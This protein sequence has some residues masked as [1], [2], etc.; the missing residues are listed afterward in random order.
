MSLRL[1]RVDVWFSASLIFCR[2]SRVGWSGVCW[3][4]GGWTRSDLSILSA[5]PLFLNHIW[6]QPADSCRLL[7]AN[8]PTLRVPPW[9]AGNQT[10]RPQLWKLCFHLTAQ[11]YFNSYLSTFIFW[12]SKW[13]CKSLF[14]SPDVFVL[15]LC[16]CSGVD[17]FC[18]VWE[19]HNACLVL[20]SLKLWDIVSLCRRR[21]LTDVLSLCSQFSLFS[22]QHVYGLLD[23]S[24]VDVA[25]IES[26]RTWT[27]FH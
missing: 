21:I 5:F 2:R 19:Q 24:D 1:L 18:S 10:S 22:L 20:P 23:S 4:T 13:N 17:R 27:L 6:I 12:S 8:L 26:V 7:E 9:C 16:L 25:S 15:L 14:Q 11:L 3:L